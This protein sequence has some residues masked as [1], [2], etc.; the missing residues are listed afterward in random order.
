MQSAINE[1]LVVKFEGQGSNFDQERGTGIT[2]TGRYSSVPDRVGGTVQIVGQPGFPIVLTSLRDDA[3]GAG[4][5]P[6][7]RPQTDTNNDG[8]ASVPRA[9]DWRSTLFDSFS[10]DRNVLTVLEIERVDTVAPGT[11]DSAVTAQFLGTLAKDESSTDE[12]LPLGFAIR[13][14]LSDANDQDVYSFVGTAGTQVWFDVDSTRF[15]LDTIIEVLNANG[16]LLVRSDDSTDEQSGV[17]SIFTTPLVNANNVNPLLRTATSVSRRNAS[18]L[19]KDD[20]TTNPRDAGVRLLLPGVTGAQS[21]YFFRIRSKSTNIENSGA[22]L[23]SGSYAVQIRLREAQEFPG[24]TVQ[25][26]NIRYATNGVHTTGLPYHSPLTGE[27]STGMFDGT[28]NDGITQLG[29]LHLTDRGAISVAGSLTAGSGNLMQ[30]S[31]GDSNLS[32]PS[33]NTLYPIVVDVDYADGL[34]RPD[35]TAYLFTPQGVYVGA[36][37][38]IADDRAGPFRGSDLADLSR[39]SVGTRDPF[40]GTIS[41]PRGTYTL[42]IGGPNSAP[43]AI[44]RNTVLF[45]DSNET[46]N[47]SPIK[48]PIQPSFIN[49]NLAAN[50]YRT[51]L[52][53][54]WQ[55]LIM[56]SGIYIY[57]RMRLNK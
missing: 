15:S 56:I 46:L 25:F 1:S 4:T 24:S 28:P 42:G 29:S 14:V 19:L 44:G 27:A 30:F 37:S 34:N 50:S 22:G 51:N 47:Y 52:N 13:G 23:T 35:T 26:A 43:A 54:F 41:L 17:D 10:N 49:L 31:L 40:I 11:N 21:T 38:N 12:N 55:P 33:F 9:G 53:Y 16:D 57:F 20:Y 6:D 45:D 39:G 32:N 2:A 7:G 36:D 48:A 8:I 18:G 5:Q 3:V